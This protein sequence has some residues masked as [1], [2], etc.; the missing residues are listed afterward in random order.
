VENVL[1]AYGQ[2]RHEVQGWVRGGKLDLVRNVVLQVQKHLQSR[3]NYDET[4]EDRG[5]WK[6]L[7]DFLQ[8]LPGDLREQAE[9]FFKDRGYA[10]P[11]PGRK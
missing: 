3:R 11:L 4:K 9:G 2:H 8:D 10:L 6:N 5:R 1:A 7:G